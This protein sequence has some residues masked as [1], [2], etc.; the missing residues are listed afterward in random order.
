MKTVHLRQNKNAVSPVIGTILMVAITV[1]LAAVLYVM[2][3]GLVT[4]PGQQK[5]TVTLS[6]GQWSG[7]ANVISI[8]S[9]PSTPITASDLSF[10][11]VA[12]NGTFWFN[13]ASGASKTTFGITVT[14]TFN[15][16]STDNKV[17]PDDNIQ[18]TVSPVNAVNTVRGATFK[19]LLATD[20]LG[21][22]P[23]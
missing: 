15:D 16:A 14:V 2:V 10:Q 18:I 1:V 23:L 19:V 6:A 4:S 11:I 9:A 13:G 7:G 5:P 12:A 8:T 20:V 3:T 22:T 21:T 17:G